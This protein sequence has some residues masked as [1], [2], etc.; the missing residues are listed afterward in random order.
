MSEEII[1][2]Y[3]IKAKKALGQNFLINDAILRFIAQAVEV[4]WKNIIEV[5]PWYGALT[6]KLLEQK[7]KKLKLIELDT[8]MIDILN[9]RIEQWE[10]GSGD[11]DFSI[12]NIDVLK[13]HPQPLLDKEG[14]YKY[15]VIANI[16]YYITS[17]IL[18]HF[19]YSLEHTPENMVI[20]LQK[21]VGDKILLWQEYWDKARTSVL[22][23]IVAKKT[24]VR[25]VIVVPS[26]NFIPAPKVESSVLLF[27][28]RS[29]YDEYSDEKFL[30]I[31]KIAFMASRKKLSKNL[32]NGWFA[33]EDVS[34]AFG[35]LNIDAMVRPENLNVEIWC[36]L[37]EE[38]L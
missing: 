31:I 16:P 28:R 1:K 14:G 36:K 15:S 6:E 9:D 32:I 26:D 33:K 35:R 12:E 17:P 18:R 8:S 13:Y 21:D 22:S 20:L 11:T 29:K 37:S 25:E 27:Q 2:R 19:L 23:L 30:Q 7:P 34:R 5:W 24:H 4:E 3:K 10:L 38:L